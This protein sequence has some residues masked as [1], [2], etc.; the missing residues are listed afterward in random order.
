MWRNWAGDQQCV[1]A[2]TERPR[3]LDELRRTV[4]DA[5]GA[6]LTVRAA[7]SG[8][9]FT[10]IACTDGVMLRLEGLNRVLEA[11]GGSG[12][13]KV[14]AG[15]VLRD[16]SEALWQR[17]LALPSLGDIDVQTVAG[18][19]STATHGTGPRFG[20]LS[21]QVEGVE[22]VLADGSVLAVDGDSDPDTLR[23]ARVSLGSLGVLATVTLRAVPA[24]ALRRHD[25]T[26][27]LGETLAS[28]DELIARNRHF[29]L[30]AFPHTEVAMCRETTEHDGEPPRERPVAE[31]AQ[32]VFLENHVFGT[33]MRVARRFPSRIPQISRLVTRAAG[34]S[35]KVARS[36]R[37]FST[38]RQVRFTEME[39]AVPR[40]SGPEALLRV[41][42]MIERRGYAVPFPI[43]MRFVGPDDAYLST[44]HGYDTCYIAV[45]MFKG[46]V[47]EPYFRAV[48]AIMDSYGGRPH[49]G[50]RHFQS[51]ATLAPRY[52]DWDRFQETR[53]RLDPGGTFQNEYSQR[54]LGP[55][56]GSLQEGAPLAPIGG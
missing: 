23:A 47:W 36:Y 10:D 45:H 25:Y 43:E 2:R 4:A 28:V 37:V 15:I 16:L 30:Y 12:L 22:L 39:Y 24:F 21:A 38:R 55:A 20:N 34:S 40:P 32:D 31:W 52:P 49:W 13:V 53:A 33:F 8:H 7:G 19:I 14:E 35:V 41:L 48:E 29:E 6:G 9:S 26:A 56:A 51:A 42:E 3:T 46:M 54:V 5:A 18:A 1:P 17:G 50:K 44:A 27:P 11:D